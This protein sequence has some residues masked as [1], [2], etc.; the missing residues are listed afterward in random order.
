MKN[1]ILITILII[2]IIF[3]IQIVKDIRNHFNTMKLSINDWYWNFSYVESNSP[4]L[5]DNPLLYTDDDIKI[6]NIY[7]II[8]PTFDENGNKITFEDLNSINDFSV[9]KPEL[10]S[11]FINP[12]FIDIQNVSNVSKQLKP[13]SKITLRGHST[14]ESIQKSYKIKLEDKEGFLESQILNLNKHPFDAFRVRNKI[15]FELFENIP[16]ITSM[17]TNLVN[18]Y[19]KDLSSFEDKEFINYGLFTNIEQPNK[20]FLKA[21]NLDSEGY[22]Y[23]AEEFEFFRKEDVIRNI[24]DPLYNESE[25]NKILE[26]K[27]AKNH[28]KIIK[29]L[30]DVNNFNLDINK[31]L[32]KH[33]NRD[34]YF[35]WLSINILLG[36]YDTRTQNYFLY[37]RHDNLAWYFLPWDY[38]GSMCT[39]FLDYEL[40][41]EFQGLA[42]VGNYWNSVLHKRV[43]REP[44]NLIELNE[45]IDEV[46]SM[47]SKENMEKVASKYKEIVEKEYASDPLYRQESKI[48]EFEKQIEYISNTTV[49]NIKLYY[50]HLEKP[51][52]I[53]LGEIEESNNGYLFFWDESF[54]LQGD[55]FTYTF[56]VSKTPDFS[57]LYFEK[58]RLRS[59]EFILDLEPGEYY[60]RVIT[61]DDKGNSQ[62][63]FDIFI[64]ENR[65]Y[66]G[67]KKIIIE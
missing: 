1:K 54:D 28:K 40:S 7:L 66:F 3:G 39:D 67:L 16:D 34:N 17:R 9:K 38:D 27:V 36:N 23:K 30:N 12:N 62:R 53:Y 31:I 13:N 64:E 4:L 47:L 55:R 33:F 21:H 18:L 14:L 8:L 6:H 19:I 10:N 35:T 48:D 42:G 65:R 58:T 15:A 32:D 24:D 25:F 11:Y 29:M 45:K 26:T 43:F 46:Y 52:P 57:E 61:V 44:N 37:S 20:R 56:E 63:A 50:E 59:N 60:W 41:G 49:N 5:M 22:L 2:L 51:M